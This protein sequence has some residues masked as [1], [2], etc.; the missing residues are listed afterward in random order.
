[1]SIDE[2]RP[3]SLSAAVMTHPRRLDAARRLA[4]QLPELDPQVV[5]D[6]D[7]TGNTLETS[8]LAWS[9]VADHATHHLVLQDDV[10]PCD[11]F[12]TRVVN[13]IADQ[14]E[15]SLSFFTD[16]GN[17]SA[18]LSRI[19]AMRDSR[20]SEIV[21][22]FVP[23]QAL[24]LPAAVARAFAG[25]RAD[26]D[27]PDDVAL[28]DHSRTLPRYVHVTNYVDHDDVPS[29]VG[30]NDLGSRR[31][32]CFTPDPRDLPVGDGVTAGLTIIPT[33]SWGTTKADVTL[34]RDPA[35]GVW[36]GVSAQRILL[37]HGLDK[38]M[39][40]KS[41]DDA[42][43]AMADQARESLDAW[44]RQLWLT[45][46]TKGVAAASGGHQATT[47]TPTARLALS[48]LAPGILRLYVDAARLAEIQADTT[49]FVCAAAETGIAWVRSGTVAGFGEIP[50]PETFF[51]DRKPW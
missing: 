29:L 21:D 27:T 49:D 46:V 43:H 10:L 19:A 38:A 37:H 39:L 20:W 33:P 8:R 24:V 1:M 51:R 15:A 4:K 16:W 5:V 45:A 41:F 3:V 13:A 17:R 26:D 32:A 22:I 35:D 30:N 36:F 23:T 14:P 25:Y 42:R 2:T 48:T 7:P 28:Y 9:A 47:R 50:L 11:G 6:P 34:R 18:N 40:D 31:S 12:E 44:L